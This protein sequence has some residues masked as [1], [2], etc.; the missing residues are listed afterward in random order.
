MFDFRDIYITF[1]LYT[2]F[3]V[4]VGLSGIIT[5]DSGGSKKKNQEAKTPPT[6]TTKNKLYQ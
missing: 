3:L 5:S 6:T 2:G 1:S 4:F